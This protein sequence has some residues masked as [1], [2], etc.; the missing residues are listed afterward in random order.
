[1]T[2]MSINIV[3]N[4]H[5]LKSQRATIIIKRSSLNVQE[6]RK[7]PTD[8][9]SRMYSVVLKLNLLILEWSSRA[10]THTQTGTET[11]RLT[12]PGGWLTKKEI[13][14]K[15]F[16][17]LLIP[18][19]SQ[20]FWGMGDLMWVMGWRSGDDLTYIAPKLQIFQEFVSV[21][22]M[23]LPPPSFIVWV[24]LFGQWILNQW[25]LFCFFQFYMWKRLY[26][27]LV[28]LQNLQG[29][30]ISNENKYIQVIQQYENYL[31]NYLRMILSVTT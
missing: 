16:Y 10:Q 21:W 31:L 12:W 28:L 7:R 25:S 24:V 27:V 4:D 30:Q 15:L 17:W 11:Y 2:T 20:N 9:F 3:L 13:K 22:C 23:F 18:I 26:G 6:N 5:W 29:I 19:C 8:F 1:M 14:E